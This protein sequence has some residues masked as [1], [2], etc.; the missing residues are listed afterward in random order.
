LTAAAQHVFCW[1]ETTIEIP[2]RGELDVPV[3]QVTR[4]DAVKFLLDLDFP[5]DAADWA[6]ALGHRLFKFREVLPVTTL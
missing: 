6:S 2:H 1:H 4:A 3:A 5:D